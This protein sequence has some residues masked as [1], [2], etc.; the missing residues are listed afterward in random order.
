METAR[1]NGLNQYDF[2]HAVLMALKSPDDE[3]DWESLLPW[4]ITLS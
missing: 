1:I 4:K 3:I 2:L